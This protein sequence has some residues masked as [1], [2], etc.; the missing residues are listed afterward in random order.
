MASE[1]TD[2]Q[3]RIKRLKNKIEY[4]QSVINRLTVEVDDLERVLDALL[5]EEYPDD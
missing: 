1:L 5:E 2:R 4:K 3:K